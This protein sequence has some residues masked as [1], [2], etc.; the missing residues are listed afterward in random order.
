M[1]GALKKYIM[2]K[3]QRL[4]QELEQ[5]AIEKRLKREKE[6][7]QVQDAMTLDQIKE[8]L[9]TLEK[10][11]E[12][13]RNEKHDLFVQLK[14]VLNEDNT[15]RKQHE[16]DRKSQQTESVADTSPQKTN[17]KTN[18][19]TNISSTIPQIEYHPSKPGATLTSCAQDY[20]QVARQITS[21]KPSRS[22][23]HLQDPSKPITLVRSEQSNTM[24]GSPILPIHSS[25]STPTLSR[26]PFNINS[27]NPDINQQYKVPQ[28]P[29]I[30]QAIPEHPNPRLSLDYRA[31]S[32][33]SDYRG[34]M[35]MDIPLSLATSLHQD[36]FRNFDVGNKRSLIAA[37]LNDSCADVSIA[38]KKPHSFLYSNQNPYLMNGIPHSALINLSQFDHID[39]AGSLQSTSLEPPVVPTSPA[40]NLMPSNYQ[41]RKSIGHQTSSNFELLIG[42]NKRQGMVMPGLNSLY[43]GQMNGSM[44][45]SSKLYPAPEAD[46]KQ[47]ASPYPPLSQQYGNTSRHMNSHHQQQE[48]H[49][50]Y[51]SP[52]MNNYHRKHHHNKSQYHH[53]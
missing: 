46:L 51:F 45:P 43:P 17:A 9:S 18:C 48:P 31:L 36:N 41:S 19:T 24:I 26:L 15:R 3:R 44:I 39:H 42:R 47:F 14:Q 29:M 40:L 32:A 2:R 27:T 33:H 53:K 5:D 11:L 21:V 1:R 52:N 38:R 28:P 30:G 37:N 23:T 49:S 12:T 13:L 7:K 16:S 4:K 35:L 50:R 8:Q 20:S 34:P 25:Y 10:R 22:S 6:L